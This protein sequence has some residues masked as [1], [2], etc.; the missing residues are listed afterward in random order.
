MTVRRRV[1]LAP[2][3]DKFVDEPCPTCGSPRSCVN[4]LWLRRVRKEAGLTLREMA[5]RLD[6]SAPFLCDVERN[7]R[8]V[9]PKVRK[10]YESLVQEAS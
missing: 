10:A 2:P 4:G 6:L 3:R 9:S 1:S 5:R 7:R 8:N